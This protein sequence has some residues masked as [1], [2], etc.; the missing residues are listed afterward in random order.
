MR[1]KLLAL[2]IVVLAFAGLDAMHKRTP[3]AHPGYAFSSL[4]PVSI[5]AFHLLSRENTDAGEV[6]GTY[7]DGSS[8]VLLD[9]RPDSREFPHNGAECFL[10]TGERPLKEDAEVIRTARGTAVF[11]IALFGSGADAKLVASTECYA[12]KCAENPL[13]SFWHAP[14][15]QPLIGLARPAFM[16]PVAILIDRH[17]QTGKGSEAAGP[18][19]IHYFEMFAAGLDLRRFEV[20][21][22]KQI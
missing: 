18:D 5:G 14:A 19:L 6:V 4:L 12:D 13:T 8:T 21:A 15:N 9:V 3:V 20:I 11:D 7:S 2:A 17:D 22:S 1:L 10:I 16:V